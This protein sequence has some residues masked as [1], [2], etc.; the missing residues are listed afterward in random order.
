VHKL[1]FIG[2][3]LVVTLNASYALDTVRVRVD[4]TCNNFMPA[5]VYYAIASKTGGGSSYMDS[6]RICGTI[7]NAYRKN[8]YLVVTDRYG[9][10]RLEGNFYDEFAAGHC[11]H[12]DD[13][14]RKTSEGEYKMITKRK[15]AYSKQTGKWKYYNSSG[16]LIK[17]QKHK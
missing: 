9:V 16:V 11:I 13:K 7:V 6:I 12:Y 4:T 1:F 10:K 3:V 17:E 5:R 8:Y 14:G 15:Y 2:I